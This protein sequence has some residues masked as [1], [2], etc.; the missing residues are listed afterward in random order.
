MS[1]FTAVN[2]QPNEV[3]APR[4]GDDIV[5]GA[6]VVMDRAFTVDST[7]A[8]AWPW[9][10]QLG[11]GRAGWYLPRSL[12]RFLPPS[13]QAA[14]VVM[15]AF[16]HLQVGDVIPDYGGK[17][18]TFE[19]AALS[20]PTTLV[21]RSRRGRTNVSWSITLAPEAAGS[22]GE[23]SVRTRIHL[24][25]R[26]GPVRHQRLAETAGDLVDLLTIGGM[27]AGLR[28]RLRGTAPG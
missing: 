16:Q 18:A 23:S 11:K 27:A 28:E 26:L 22:V 5:A 6:D 12:E 21:Y 19:V 4:A 3:A 20:P 7:P 2:P 13:R 1:A 14:R 10:V 8:E 17:E 15:P 24:R 9:L 25:L